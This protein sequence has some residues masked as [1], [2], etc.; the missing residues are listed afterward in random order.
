MSSLEFYGERLREVR[1][2]RGYSLQQVADQLGITKQAVSL[3]EKA[4][5]LPRPDHFHKLV[6]YLRVPAHYFRRPPLSSHSSPT[7]YRSMATATKKMRDAAEQ[8][9]K[10]SREIV[11]FFS[12]HVEL[13][14]VCLP[15]CEFPSNSSLITVES[16]EDSAAELRR[17][18]N[19]GSGVISNVVH[20]LEN[21]GIVVVRFSLGTD[22]LDA[23]S[24]IEDR[25][26]RP[27]IVLSA[28]KNNYF[29]SRHDAAHE[30][31]HL[32]L[33]RNVP[34][35]V[36]RD[37]PTFNEIEKQAHRFA[38]AFLLPARTFRKEWITP[39]IESFK[40]IKLK[41]KAA[42]SAM[43]MRAG[44]LGIVSESQRESLL[45]SLGRKGWRQREPFDDD[46]DPELPRFFSRACQMIVS[47]L[48]LSRGQI[49]DNLG[50]ERADVET[51]LGLRNFFEE[52]PLPE[53]EEPQP[54]LKFPP[55]L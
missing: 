35:Q 18:W 8:K 55:P 6:E 4:R 3:Y 20:L 22:K 16:I 36:L 21:K 40:K 25:T 37:S 32:I 51:I 38:S 43:V 11:S 5:R 47:E 14:P 2:A 42:I 53:V 34:P 9:L 48:I 28:D 33:H 27:Y 39:N 54:V 41:W 15:P 31:G 29:R 26:S 46:T 7:F 12:Q 19:L 24:F 30:L 45:I 17:F 52:A 44:D 10:W 23:L 50:L 1:E 49:L 13:N